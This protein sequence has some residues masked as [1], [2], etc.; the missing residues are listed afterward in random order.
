MTLGPRH[1]VLRIEFSAESFI[2]Q[3]ANA[4]AFTRELLILD[5][6]EEEC[7]RMFGIEVENIGDERIITTTGD[8][9]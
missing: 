7:W 2:R 6:L 4:Q 9:Q 8:Q 5:A 1:G 3:M